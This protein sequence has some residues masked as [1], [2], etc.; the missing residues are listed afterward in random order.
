V[1]VANITPFVAR[2]HDRYLRGALLEALGRDAEAL[3]WFASLAGLSVPESPFRAP[4]HLRQAQIHERLGN[5]AEAARHYARVM[6]L[7]GMGDEEVL[8]GLREVRRRA[9][10]HR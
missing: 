7:W 5:E 4:A 9:R 8:A 1:G 6:E 3:P 2:A 10:A